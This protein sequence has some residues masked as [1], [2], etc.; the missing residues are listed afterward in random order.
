[1][2]KLIVLLLIVALTVYMAIPAMAATPEL[3]PPDLPEIPDISDGIHVEL[4][5]GFWGDYFKRHPLPAIKLPAAEN[6]KPVILT[7]ISYTP[8]RLYLWRGLKS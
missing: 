1:M 4:P 6:T 5:A 7:P 2:K 3:K 8:I